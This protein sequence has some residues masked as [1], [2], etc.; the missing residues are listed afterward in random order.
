MLN[1]LQKEIKISFCFRCCFTYL[2]E[3]RKHIRWCRYTTSFFTVSCVWLF[4]GF[5][6]ICQNVLIFHSIFCFL[7]SGELTE[8]AILNFYWKLWLV[9]RIFIL[10]AKNH[11]ARTFCNSFQKIKQK[12]NRIFIA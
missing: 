6:N 7:C 5:S 2:L 12:K 8:F 11:R 10:F 3:I 4:V 9:E 1:S